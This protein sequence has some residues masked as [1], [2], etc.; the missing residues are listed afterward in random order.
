MQIYCSACGCHIT[1]SEFIQNDVFKCPN[2]G[3]TFVGAKEEAKRHVSIPPW[4]DDP[5]DKEEE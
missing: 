5:A 3:S 1:K 4:E 2:C